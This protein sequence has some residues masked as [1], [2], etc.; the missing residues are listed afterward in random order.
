MVRPDQASKRRAVLLLAGQAFALG[1]VVAWITIGATAIFLDTYGAGALPFTYIGAAVAGALASSALAGALRRRS[2]VSVAKRVLAAVSLLLGGAFVALWL[3][4]P[5]VSV[6]LVVLIPIL[7]PLG[8]VFIVGQA[9]AL[10]DVRTLKASYSR[11]IAGFAVGFV[12]GGIAGPPLL[13]AV[14]RTEALLAFAGVVAVMFFLL[15]WRT[16]RAFPAQLSM[17]EQAT[18][19]ET[20]KPS[21]RSLLRNRYVVYLVAFQMLSAVE[22]QWLDYLVYDRAAARYESSAALADFISRFT[23]IAYGADIVFLVAVAGLLLKRFGLRYGLT[24]N[25]AVVLTLVVAILVTTSLQSSGTLLVFVLVVASRVSDLTLSDGTSR[26]SLGA[27][28]QAVPLVERLAVQATVEGLAVPLAIGLSGVVLIALRETIGVGGLALP[29]ATSIV[30]ITWM[31][32]SLLVYRGYGLNLLANLRHRMLDPTTI[33]VSDA[34]T[35][36]AI[37]RLLESENER[38]VRL[39][40]QTLAVAGHPELLVRLGR[41]ALDDRI[42]VRSHSL[43]RLSEIDP[44]A[45]ATS[46]RVGLSHH[47]AAIRA[48]CLRTL[49]TTG[50]P[51]D[52]AAV[53]SHWDDPNH[54]VRVAAAVAISQLGDQAAR[55]R[56]SVAVAELARTSGLDGPQLAARVL[57]GCGPG[58]GIDR[59]SLRQLLASSHYEVVNAALAVVSLPTDAA[60]LG[61]I[62]VHLENR[63]TSAAAVEALVR[64]GQHSLE[65]IDRGLGEDL[66]VG[67][68]GKAG[69]ARAC[70]QIGGDAAAAV[71][72]SHLDDRDR[73]VG[74]AVAVALTEIAADSPGTVRPQ[75]RP[76]G[77]DETVDRMIR[78]SLTHAAHALRAMQTLDVVDEFVIV[79]RALRDELDLV[80]KQLLACLAWRYGTESLNRITF[81]LAQPDPRAH[82]VAMEWLDVTLTGADRAVMALLE[83][84]WSLGER[85]RSIGRWFPLPDVSVETVLPD[86]IAD[87]D[88]RW[89]RPWLAA[90]ALMAMASTQPKDFSPPAMRGGAAPA[91]EEG[92]EIDIVVE[93]IVGIRARRQLTSPP[94]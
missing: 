94:L 64:G 2:L 51:D 37:D 33:D 72:L 86:L 77:A 20:V 58:T 34:N 38:D 87:P 79:R 68:H 10:L 56:I 16:E 13:D 69:L 85:T 3:S 84:D 8:F 14:N 80:Q 66:R 5:W 43:D 9:G 55:Q 1:L 93:T 24:A 63:R 39:G 42:G 7:V 12:V 70:A 54:D 21:I 28:Y 30:L 22:S 78:T 32:V 48:V 89:R 75:T 45:A 83:P 25:S 91:G 57:A 18:A 59:S 46:A 71:L 44:A 53:M 60:L 4:G 92:A 88:D 81:Q 52:L 36:A 35:L 26:T 15:V 61:D 50:A 31:A 27:A 67:R 49:A 19:A 40:L 65:L 74:L 17:L 23:A 62:L 47:D 82:S 73:E 29:V 90:C 76:A 41:L 11:V 6:V